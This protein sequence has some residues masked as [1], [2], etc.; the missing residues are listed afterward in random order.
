MQ[1]NPSKCYVMHMS[2]ARNPHHHDYTLCNQKLQVVSSHPYLGVHLQDDL[3]WNTHI[4]HATSK[5]SRMLGVVRRNLYRCPEN[6]K[7]TAYVSLVRPLIEYASVAWDP[8]Q[9]G[10]IRDLEK[11]QRGA[12]R[13]TKSEYSRTKGTVTDLLKELDWSSLE[14]RRRK[15]RLTLMYKINNNLV[16][17]S[18]DRYLIPATRRSRHTNSKSFIQT[19]AR[20][21]VHKYSYFPR[22]VPEWNALDDTIVQAPSL[23]TFKN[24]LQ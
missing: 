18:S 7:Q 1:F 23:D 24:L 22:T 5:A 2:L 12:A 20:I 17:I 14:E 11:I 16:D 21:N 13:F 8:Y 6:L 19:R 3:G 9:K 10:H 4:G 15:A